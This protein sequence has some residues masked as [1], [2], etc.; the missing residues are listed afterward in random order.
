MRKFCADVLHLDET[1]DVID[2]AS[3]VDAWESSSIRMAVRHKA[4]VEVG[5][6]SQPRALNKVEIQDLLVKFEAVHG[7]K[8]EN[9]NVPAAAT[10]EQIFD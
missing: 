3:M 9:R 5:L 6:A 7:I 4:E 10:L 1:N 2:I 8:L